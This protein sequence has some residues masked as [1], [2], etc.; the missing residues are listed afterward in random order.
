[1]KLKEII[2]RN[3]MVILAAL[4]IT[5]IFAFK[6]AN[7]TAEPQ[8]GWYSISSASNNPNQKDDQEINGF[9]STS[10]PTGDCSPS[11]TADLCQVH[12]DLTNFS[13]STPIENM[14]VEDAILAGA[15]ASTYARTEEQ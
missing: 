1:M 6:I 9:V 8:S 3:S 2:F 15:Q 11:N 14:T 10:A 12:L 5:S 13:S 4:M 7:R